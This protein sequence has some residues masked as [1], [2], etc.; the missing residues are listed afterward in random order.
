GLSVYGEQRGCA[1]CDF[2]GDGRVDL[3]VSQNGAET[4]LYQNLGARP[5]LR[6]RLNGPA[7]NLAGSG[8]T[9]RLISGQRPGPA[10]ELHAGSGYWSQDGAVPVMASPEPPTR[11]EVRW[12][13]GRVT[14]A[15]L[16]AGAKD[17]AVDVSGKVTVLR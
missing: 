6:V 12:P 7:G 5:G 11:V 3:A 9:I 13:G 14:T 8:A 4:K 1:L 16:A 2:D 10:R 17:I 15:D